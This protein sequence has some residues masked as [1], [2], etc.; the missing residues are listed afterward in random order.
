MVEDM[1]ADRPSA[2]PSLRRRFVALC[3]II[4]VGLVPLACGSD[5]PAGTD[6]PG[7]GPGPGAGGLKVVASFYPLAYVV[8]RIG[9][10]RVSVE[11]LT[12][13]GAEPHDLELTASDTAH[14]E[15]A[16]LIVYLA[17]FSPAVDDGVAAAGPAHAID[18]AGSARLDL[19]YSPI[20]NGTQSTAGAGRRDPHFWL[21]PTRLIDVATA[22]AA[23]LGADDPADAAMFRA[24]A[25]ALVGELQ[26]LDG[27]YAKGLA[28]CA[29]TDIVTSHNAFGYLAERYGLTQV[30][31]TGLTPEDEPTPAD[32]AAVTQFVEAH[33]VTTIYYE[34]LV[35][36]AIADTV[37]NETGATTE[38]LDPIE[39]LSDSSQGADYF[40]IMRSN[41]AHLRAGQGCS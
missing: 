34:T 37:A 11:N 2:R 18:V 38:V 22:L 36:P 7:T 32:L 13:V 30:G 28:S 6:A 1:P 9:G 5:A 19:T 35:S 26:A 14:L 25:A 23:R 29:D 10:D 17:G 21:D 16:D 20:E 40:G 24:N 33:H 3:S 15:D 41:L 27:E 8:Q 4:V 31:I 39:G 12:P